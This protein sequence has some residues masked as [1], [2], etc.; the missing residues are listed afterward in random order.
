VSRGHG[1]RLS[2]R[3]EQ[4]V[5]ALLTH[6]TIGSAAEAAGIS[7]RT[8]RSWLREP[9]FRDAYRQARRQLLD[10]AVLLLQRASKEAV[11]ALI[12]QL[13]ASKPGDVI[14]AA[15]AILDHAYRG[16]E[17]IDLADAVDDL[18]RQV[19]ESRREGGCHDAAS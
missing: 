8:L 4:A 9:P 19:E 15:T 1:D 13:R 3:Q 5:A 18:R 2:H 12:Q 7:E 10:G 11:E 16:T 6:R 14:R 17:V